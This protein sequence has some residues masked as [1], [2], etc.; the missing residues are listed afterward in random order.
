MDE[1]LNISGALAALFGAIR[2]GNAALDA[3]T[4]D[5]SEAAALVELF[6]RWNGALGVL[7]K[8]LEA[9]PAE[10]QALLDRRQAARADKE[11]AQ[12]DALRDEI[13]ALG[14][15]VKDTPNG[16]VASKA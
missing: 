15:Q 3:K 2:E 5:A 8:P 7:E 10:V 1:D 14:W 9:I 4:L 6:R 13:L 12:S 16:Q 11:W